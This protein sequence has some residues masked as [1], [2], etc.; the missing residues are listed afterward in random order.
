MVHL[1]ISPADTK[2]GSINLESWLQHI[3]QKY[4]LE[5]ITLLRQAVSLTRVAGEE[6][7]TPNGE[8]CLHQGLTMAEILAELNPDAETLAAAIVYSSMRY[9][10]LNLEDVT[11]H[12]GTKVAKLAKGTWQ[13]DAINILRGENYHTHDPT[14]IDNIRKMLLAM[15]DNVNV[16]LIKLAERLCILRNVAIFNDNKKKQVAKETMDIYAPLANRLG[17]GQLKWQLEDL[18]FRYLQPEQYKKI[19]TALKERRVDREQYIHQIV[20]ELKTL[21]HESDIQ[22]FKIA[23]RAKH[24]YSIY[25]KMQ[26]KNV[27]LAEIY[28]VSAVRILVPNIE[29]CYTALSSVHTRWQ[30]IKKEFDDYIAT[31]KSNGYRSIHTAVIGPNNKSV[32]IQI[33]TFQMHEESELGVAAH[34]IYKEGARKPS[35]Y[36]E[37]ISWLRQVLDW[38][39]EVAK[40]EAAKEEIQTELF[41][42]RI[43]VFTPNGQVLDLPKGATPLDFAYHVH[44]ELGHRCR[45][46]KVNGHIVPLTYALKTGE[47]VEILTVKAGH[48]SRDWLNPHLNYLKTPRAK[49]KVLQWFRKQ[50]YEKNLAEGK[51][52]IEREQKRLGIK[53]V[54]FDQIAQKLNYKTGDDLLAAL[55]RG[56]L[57]INTLIHTMQPVLLEVATELK[58]EI[59]KPKLSEIVTDIDIHGVGNLLTHMAL[60]CQP[61]PGDKIIGYV[62]VGRGISIHRQDCANIAHNKAAHQE[63]L[64]EVSWGN[65][66]QKNYIANLII[67]AQDRQKSVQDIT[68]LL[69]NENIPL[70]SIESFSDKDHSQMRIHLSIEISGLASL[71]KLLALINQLPNVYDVKRVS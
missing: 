8:S 22:D 61:V 66:T 50:D 43:Y 57:G 9:A 49:A 64:V 6:H 41:D 23:G 44:S 18:S 16:V 56:D 7:A 45:G 20:A 69:V 11:E 28:D 27:P 35:S 71:S 33:R 5:N 47:Q 65:K 14:S 21:L 30:H 70:L 55:G 48:P 52:Q 1:T 36:E 2:E 62:T 25:R 13:M 59:I 40:T 32:E 67:H 24:I 17:I 39:K 54:D 51:A 29:D 38:Q 37:K 63:R 3:S 12:L 26:R 68:A 15:V 34:W 19:S 31:P 46:A 60:C 58:P 42:D 4:S 53:Q 10:G